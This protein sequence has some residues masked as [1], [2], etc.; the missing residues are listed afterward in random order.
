MHRRN[1][2][3]SG[4]AWCSPFALNSTFAQTALEE[5]ISLP[6]ARRLHQAGSAILIDIREP[7]EHA[8]GVAAGAR[9]L[10]MSQLGQRVREIPVDS[11]VPVLLI[12]RTQNRS[13]ATLRALRRQLG[14]Q[15][16]AHVRFVH[17]GMSEWAQR[18][19]PMVQPPKP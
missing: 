8:T 6:D 14:E 4:A 11:T 5:Q 15:N 18:G 3:A 1:L 7:D 19:W 12:C 17:G 10:P 16:Y 9:L 13:S 2:L